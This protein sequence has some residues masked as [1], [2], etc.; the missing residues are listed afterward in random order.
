MDKISNKNPKYNVITLLKKGGSICK[1]QVK[2]NSAE[3]LNHPMTDGFISGSILPKDDITLPENEREPFIESMIDLLSCHLNIHP[4]EAIR[5]AM[6]DDL[7][8]MIEKYN[9]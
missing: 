2:R 6:K 3:R 1:M 5:K 4:D 8:A 7:N 9:Q